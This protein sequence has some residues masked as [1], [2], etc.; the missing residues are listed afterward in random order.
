MQALDE[1]APAP[2]RTGALPVIPFDVL[3]YHFTF[4]P[5]AAPES[6]ERM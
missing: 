3:R 5:G 1:L 6:G 2:Q 4:M